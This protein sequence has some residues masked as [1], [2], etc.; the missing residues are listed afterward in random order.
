M[1]VDRA[2]DAAFKA[3]SCLGQVWLLVSITHYLDVQL[4]KPSLFVCYNKDDL[5][6]SPAKTLMVLTTC[7]PEYLK[8]V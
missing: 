3:K 8:S 5:S 4:F 6:L 2:M 7:H 1:N